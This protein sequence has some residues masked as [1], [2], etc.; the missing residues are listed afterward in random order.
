MPQ[1]NQTDW[2]EWQG[3]E[4]PV[5]PETYCYLM[6]ADGYVSPRAAPA[7]TAGADDLNADDWWTYSCAPGD[8]IIAYRVA[9]L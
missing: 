6:T 3:G 9:S 8:R 1:E 4:C 5:D 7:G 2:I